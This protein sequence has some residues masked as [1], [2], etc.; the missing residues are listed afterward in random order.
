MQRIAFSAA[1]LVAC[2]SIA[3]CITPQGV[4]MVNKT[5]RVLTVEYLHVHKDGSTSAYSTAMLAPEG[6]LK[7]HPPAPEGF[8]AERVRLAVADAPNEIGHSLVLHIPDG[9][10]RDF[11]IQYV[12]GRLVAREH[13]KGRDHT[14]T[15][16]PDWGK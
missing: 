8:Q 2:L 4:Q 13:R 10:T 7:H 16:E 6:Q 15:G 12:S 5:G 14:R 9:R 1:A 3:G 11:D